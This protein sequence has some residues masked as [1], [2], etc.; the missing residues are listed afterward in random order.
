MIEQLRK[1][2]PLQHWVNQLF[3]PRGLALLQL[4]NCLHDFIDD[5]LELVGSMGHRVQLFPHQLL[6]IKAIHYLLSYLRIFDCGFD[7]FMLVGLRRCS[8]GLFGLGRHCLRRVGLWRGLWVVGQGRSLLR[9]VSNEESLIFFRLV[10]LGGCFELEGW[11]LRTGLNGCLLVGLVGG[12]LWMVWSGLCSR[13]LRFNSDVPW[14]G[15]AHRRSYNIN[16]NRKKIELYKYVRIDS[17]SSN[18]LNIKGILYRTK[19]SL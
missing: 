2:D 18:V 12:C 4:D 5:A 15:A 17:I 10:G 6:Q 1:S 11:G 8:L 16:I 9:V 13:R 7:I 3:F 19:P 14:G